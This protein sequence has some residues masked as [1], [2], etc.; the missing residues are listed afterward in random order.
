MNSTKVDNST[1]PT[2]NK[3]DVI[4]RASHKLKIMTPIE[5]ANDLIK[6]YQSLYVTVQGCNEGG[7]PCIITNNMYSNA[8]I[9]CA[10]LAVDEI[11]EGLNNENIIYG[12][13]YRY[14][15]SNYY[16]NVKKELERL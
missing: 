2:L 6:K 13:E 3:A 9:R 12:S 1:N 5:K 16:E 4:G 10:K 8:A 7:N 15:V 11:L 14:E